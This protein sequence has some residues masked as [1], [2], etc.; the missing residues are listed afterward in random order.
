MF[1]RTGF[2]EDKHFLK[3]RL[4]NILWL[5]VLL[6]SLHL[7]VLVL[8]GFALVN[9]DQD[10]VS[11]STVLDSYSPYKHPVMGSFNFSSKIKVGLIVDCFGPFGEGKHVLYDG[12]SGSEFM[13]LAGVYRVNGLNN[14]IFQNVELW[15]VDNVRV[16]KAMDEMWDVNVEKILL[17]STS[18]VLVI[19]FQ[20]DPSGDYGY[21]MKML[22]AAETPRVRLAKRSIVVDRYLA[23]RSQIHL[24]HLQANNGTLGGPTLHISYCVRNDIVHEVMRQTNSLWNETRAL[25]VVHLWGANDTEYFSTYRSQISSLLDT[26]H[27][28][29]VAGRAITTLT[30]LQGEH[31]HTGRWSASPKYVTALLRSKIVVVTQRDRWEDSYRLMEAFASGAM[32]LADTML[33]PPP[34]IVDG[35]H[36]RFFSS[37]HDLKILI[38]YYLLHEQDRKRIAYAGWIEAM[39]RHRA[40][41]RMEELVFGKALTGVDTQLPGSLTWAKI[42]G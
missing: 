34:G 26:M 35:I 14:D 9:T 7:G 19:E 13:D 42:G 21:V 8:L 33:A 4:H 11:E 5:L 24:G 30:A 3:P 18:P 22:D 17:N 29:V 1:A 36:L 10:Y 16:K 41:H 6:L 12:I 23:K 27:G 38:A 32:V 37:K 25:D 15:V 28:R 31:S 2:K 20:D 39:S 40:W